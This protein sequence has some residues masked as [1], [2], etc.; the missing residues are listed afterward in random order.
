MPTRRRGGSAK[1]I[2][3]AYDITPIVVGAILIVL[4]ATFFSF[5]YLGFVE[6]GN[7]TTP[8]S[9]TWMRAT[10]EETWKRF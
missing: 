10:A 4:A 1:A 7:A 9:N 5:F 8:Q 6:G 3:A 2:S